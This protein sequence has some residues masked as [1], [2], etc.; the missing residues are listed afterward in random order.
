MPRRH[1][2][3]RRC[4]VLTLSVREAAH[5]TSPRS[6]HQK[7]HSNSC[8][9]VLSNNKCSGNS[10]K[11]A[12]KAFQ[13]ATKTTVSFSNNRI[14]PTIS[15]PLRVVQ[16][17]SHSLARTLAGLTRQEGV[18]RTAADEIS[19]KCPPATSTSS[20]QQMQF[21]AKLQQPTYLKDSYSK[22]KKTLNQ[23]RCS[24][25]SRS[26]AKQ[27]KCLPRVSI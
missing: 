25:P 3:I 27:S 1:S 18:F 14:M 17:P 10:S 6:C 24:L 11:M 5:S 7:N 12:S 19:R 16:A 4:T 21:R 20:K 8:L 26:M 15:C 22:V 9:Q 2:T 23:E 13:L